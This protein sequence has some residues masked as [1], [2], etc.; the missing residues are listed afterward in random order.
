MPELI[1]CYEYVNADAIAAGLSPFRP[2]E[3]SV[4]AG[5]LMLKRIRELAESGRAFAFETTLAS[6]SFAPFLARCKR[7]GYSIRLI[8]IWVNSVELAVERVKRRVES[9]GHHVP[10]GTVRRR[11]ERSL[12]NFFRLYLPLADEWR[13]Y[14]NSLDEPALIARK[15]HGASVEI[16]NSKF[17]ESL[18]RETADGK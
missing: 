16:S 11:Y 18:R 6:K 9:G 3:V 12:K 4:D 1:D 5:R 17:W 14:D 8:Y 7:Q 2:L 15:L 13:F 10:E